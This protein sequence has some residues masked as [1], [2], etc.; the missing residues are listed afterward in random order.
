MSM[1]YCHEHDVHYDTDNVSEC[2]ECDMDDVAE[3]YGNQKDLSPTRKA[4]LDRL[5]KAEAK[6]AHFARVVTEQN[7]KLKRSE[8][9]MQSW[10]AIANH[11]AELIKQYADAIRDDQAPD[12]DTSS[13]SK[14]FCLSS[15]QMCQLQDH[16]P[17]GTRMGYRSH[18]VT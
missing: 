8:R 13:E 1:E 17:A 6:A 15:R 12:L 16:N 11:R 4:F 10:R 2:P 18:T 14:V 3:V 5:W 9:V 7:A